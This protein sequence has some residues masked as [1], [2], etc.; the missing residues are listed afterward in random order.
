MGCDIIVN[1]LVSIFSYPDGV[2]LQNRARKLIPEVS[3]G[4]FVARDGERFS[5]SEQFRGN[6]RDYR[7]R[8]LYEKVL[9]TNMIKGLEIAL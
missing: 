8:E 4:G 6:R 3:K 1:N 2:T 5:E 7:T 9:W